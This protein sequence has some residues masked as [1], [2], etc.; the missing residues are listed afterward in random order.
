[1]KFPA[2]RL[3]ADELAP[4]L[5]D[6]VLHELEVGRVG[7]RDVQHQHVGAG[8]DERLPAELVACRGHSLQ[9]P[10]VGC[11]SGVVLGRIDLGGLEQVGQQTTPNWVMIRM[12][13]P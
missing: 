13:P 11:T 7:G 8:E 6:V 12:S 5:R 9:K 3:V 2:V 4:G 10:T 1:M